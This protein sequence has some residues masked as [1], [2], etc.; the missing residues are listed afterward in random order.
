M[1]KRLHLPARL[2]RPLLPLQPTSQ[3][4]TMS[5][6]TSQAQGQ[7]SRGRGRRPPRDA[8]ADADPAVAHNIRFSKALSYALRHG[9]DELGLAMS[10][11]GYVQVS[12]LLAHNKFKNYTL[13]D[14]QA[15]VNN[16][17]K[18]RFTL[19]HDPDTDT[20]R[21]KANQGH[22]LKSVTDLQLTALTLDTIPPV[23]VHGTSL[24]A[25]NN[26]IKAQ[27]LKVMSRHHVHCAKGLPGESGVISGMRRASQVMVFI[28][29][30]LAVQD[31]MEWFESPNGV[32]LSSGFEGVI[33]PKYFERVVDRK[34]NQLM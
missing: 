10:A 15:V 2:T 13:A 3:L 4:L 19:T 5:S 29:V 28:N 1:L 7:S 22:S 20:W 27:G 9:A 23:V 11:D 34:G 8:D 21:V 33:A 6:F 32:I 14:L 31:G 16:N 25:W 17:D 24:D 12:D 30:K 26:G 18:Q